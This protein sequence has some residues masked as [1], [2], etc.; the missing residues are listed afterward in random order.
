MQSIQNPSKFICIIHD[1]IDTT[2][3]AIPRMQRITK[4]IVGLGQILISY[5]NMLTHGHGNGA[6]AHDATS[7]WLGD[8]NFTISS[9]Y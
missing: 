6:Y 7:L 1:K 3:I 8:S 9:L 2:K 5:T 4:A